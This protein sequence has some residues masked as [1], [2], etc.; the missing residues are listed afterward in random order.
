MPASVKQGGTWKTLTG[1]HVKN[2]GTWKEVLAAHVK[3][4]GTWKQFYAKASGVTPFTITGFSPSSPV[5]RTRVG[6]GIIGSGTIT[7][8]TANGS[9]SLSYSW[10]VVANNAGGAFSGGTTSASVLFN[11]GSSGAPNTGQTT[12]RCTVTDAGDGNRQQTADCVIDWEW[13]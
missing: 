2:G 11:T 10:S 13:V 7:V 3:N 1:L 4:G 6:T 5:F 9:G 8:Q 12:L